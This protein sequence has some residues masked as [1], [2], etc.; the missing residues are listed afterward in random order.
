MSEEMKERE[1]AVK[2]AQPK[3]VGACLRRKTTAMDAKEAR[4]TEKFNHNRRRLGQKVQLLSLEEAME[5]R[6]QR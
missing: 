6:G 5:G 4:S 2:R 1:E 3:C